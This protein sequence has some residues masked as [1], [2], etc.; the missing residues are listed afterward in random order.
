MAP[1]VKYMR[2]G[3]SFG[4][5][6]SGRKDYTGVIVASRD[7]FFLLPLMHMNLATLGA[8]GLGGAIGGAIAGALAR[9][10][11]KGGQY[12]SDAKDVTEMDLAD[13]P[14]EITGDPDWPLKKAKGRVLVVPRHAITK[15][16]YSFW[17]HFK[18][19]TEERTFLL[20]LSLFR[21][22]RVTNFLRSV[23]WEF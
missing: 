7:A 23:G 6:T 8:I 11:S 20:E 17:G 18:L 22:R 21:R 9:A 10:A 1:S 2:V 12:L 19:I 14:H 13:L 16:K 15:I 4:I 3:G 5:R